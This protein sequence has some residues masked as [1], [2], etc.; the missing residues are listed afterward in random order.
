MD[1]REAFGLNFNSVFKLLKF[2][3]NKTEKRKRNLLCCSHELQTCDWPR[4]VGCGSGGEVQAVS[5]ARTQEPPPRQRPQQQL[6]RQQQQHQQPPQQQQQ[7]QYV[8]QRPLQR[9]EAI[10][11]VSGFCQLCVFFRTTRRKEHLLDETTNTFIGL[12]INQVNSLVC[13]LL[14]SE[15]LKCYK[16]L[17]WQNI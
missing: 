14:L 3:N 7:Q 11:K 10:P 2:N 1:R 15:D 13:E 4:N 17:K 9:E 5:T 8:P 16:E 12:Y 6:S